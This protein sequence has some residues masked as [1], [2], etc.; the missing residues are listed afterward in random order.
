MEKKPCLLIADD[1]LKNFIGT[2]KLLVFCFQ[3]N[4]SPNMPN[5]LMI[6]KG[7]L[8]DEFSHYD[9][10]G[11]HLSKVSSGKHALMIQFS[12]DN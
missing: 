1:S 3:F 10:F 11:H 8:N 7:S 6:V 12:H 5:A 2:P 4:Q 9:E